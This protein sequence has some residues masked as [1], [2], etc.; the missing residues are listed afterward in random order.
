MYQTKHQEQFYELQ[1]DKTNP[2]EYKCASIS[3]M[4]AVSA[5]YVSMFLY[6]L[7]NNTI[8]NKQHILIMCNMADDMLLSYVREKPL[9]LAYT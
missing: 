8:C 7:F 1:L 3:H 6:Q 5:S 9:R 2:S 4:Y